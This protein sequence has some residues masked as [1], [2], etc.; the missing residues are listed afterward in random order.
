[1]A[2]FLFVFPFLVAILCPKGKTTIF[3]YILN[4][5]AYHSCVLHHLL[6]GRPRHSRGLQSEFQDSQSYTEKPCLEKTKKQK[7]YM[8]FKR[9]AFFSFAPISRNKNAY[10]TASRIFTVK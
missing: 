9:L 7:P 3:I 5:Y 4:I 8:F 6:F 10:N 2:P 1:M